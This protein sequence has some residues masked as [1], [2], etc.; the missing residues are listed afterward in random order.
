MQWIPKLEFWKLGFENLGLAGI[1]YLRKEP[2]RLPY[3]SFSALFWPAILKFFLKYIFN[4]KLLQ[5]DYNVSQ[6]Y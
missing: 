5:Q 3:C 1:P 6:N 4:S 2:A